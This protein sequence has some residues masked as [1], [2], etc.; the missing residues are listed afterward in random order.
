VSDA[1][2][3]FVTVPNAVTAA[4]IAS[5]VVRERLAACANILPGVRS[6][7]AWKGKVCDDRELLVVLKTTA[8]RYEALERRVKALH[9]YEVPE[10]IALPV[11]RGS[12]PYLTWVRESVR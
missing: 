4:R 2:A 5:A 7:Y 1:L 9:P 6:I 8:T 11:T 10:I 12:R 3:V